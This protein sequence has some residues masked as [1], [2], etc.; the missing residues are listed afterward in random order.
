MS[1]TT[2]A[3][4]ALREM[5]IG[6]GIKPGERLVEL[7]LVERL[8]VSRTPIRAAL[9][10]LA[11]EGLI[12]RLPSGGYVSRKFNEQDIKDAADARGMVEGMAARLCAERSVSQDAICQLNKH[13]NQIE[14]LLENRRLSSDD[15]EQYLLINDR[16]HQDLVQM[17]SSFVV[18]HLHERVRALPFASPSVFA[19]AEAEYDQS[20]KIFFIAQEQHRGIVE[21]IEQREGMR[22][23]ALAREHARLALKTLLR[24]FHN[25]TSSAQLA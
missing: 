22:A 4:I 25:R 13:L 16:F 10:T 15:I 5:I 14:R 23:E 20:W 7:P 18:E 2:K 1:Q 9:A 12:D 24:V 8:N 6:G 3:L 17:S 21:A 11:E 19:L